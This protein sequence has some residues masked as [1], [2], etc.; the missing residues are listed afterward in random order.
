MS[1]PDTTSP[2]IGQGPGCVP[3]NPPKPGESEIAQFLTVAVT[4]V[5]DEELPELPTD[6]CS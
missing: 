1:Y 5:L 2:Q 3:D 6:N 4:L